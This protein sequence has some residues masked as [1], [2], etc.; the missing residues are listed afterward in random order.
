MLKR[1]VKKNANMGYKST[2]TRGDYS[3]VS[4]ESMV[5]FGSD[6]FA[7]FKVVI[8]SKIIAVII[9]S[10]SQRPSVAYYSSPCSSKKE[11]SHFEKFM[12]N[13]AKKGKHTDKQTSATAPH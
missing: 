12:K 1:V 10:A 3:G 6:S 9:S 5:K 2:N 13:T 8:L 4:R 11:K 7:L